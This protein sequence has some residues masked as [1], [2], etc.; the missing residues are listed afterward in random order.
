MKKLISIEKPKQIGAKIVFP[1]I[2]DIIFKQEK[3]TKENKQNSNS[4]TKKKSIERIK[5][6]SINN[7]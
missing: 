5:K 1:R 6:Y 3:Q 2:Y 7:E 4:N